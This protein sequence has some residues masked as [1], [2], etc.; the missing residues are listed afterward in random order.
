MADQQTLDSSTPSPPPPPPQSDDLSHSP[1]P[2]LS[3]RLN[4]SAPEFVPARPRMMIP[5]PPPHMYLHYPSPPLFTGPHERRRDRKKKEQPETG[6]SVSIDP[7]SGLP[8]DTVQ[9]IVKQVEYYFGDLN[10]ATT[11][12]LMRF[13]SKDPQGYVPVHVVA[14]F[15]KIKSFINSDSQLASVLQYSSKFVV[16]EDGQK[17]RRIY[18]ITKIALEE[19]QSRIVIAGNLPADHCYHNLMKIFSAVG[20]V[21]HIRTCQPQNSGNGF[22]SAARSANTDFSNKVAELNEERNWRSGLRVRLMLQDQTKEPKHV[23]QEGGR[24]EDDDDKK[25]EDCGGERDGHGEE[26]EQGDKKRRGHNRGGQG[27]GRSQQNQNEN[28]K[29]NQNYHNGR[30][31]HHPSNNQMHN[32]TDHQVSMGKQQPPR[33]PRMPDG[34]R[35]FS[36]GRGKPVIVH[37]Q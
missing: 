3:S 12:L 19:L 20:S 33:G 21:K 17:V 11:D 24:K 23:L 18:P 25:Y 1:A 37:P 10:L 6:A 29:Q 7:K 4:A 16:S 2:P 31:N 14:S 15:N 9:K 30:G 28:S 13:I 22:P 34:T 5:P 35:G 26:E 27:R 8:E 32:N 36:L